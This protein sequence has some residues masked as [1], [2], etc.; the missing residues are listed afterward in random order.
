MSGKP[1]VVG[2]PS[3]HRE[4]A[5]GQTPRIETDGHQMGELGSRFSGHKEV[6]VAMLLTWPMTVVIR[7]AA[8]EPITPVILGVMAIG[9]HHPITCT[10]T[11]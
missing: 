3:I 9:Q 5:E 1:S 11:H 4:Q 10:G 8:A 7:L 6:K 2:D